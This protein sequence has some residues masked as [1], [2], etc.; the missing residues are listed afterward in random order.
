[1]LTIANCII[2]DTQSTLKKWHVLPQSETCYHNN[3]NA[4]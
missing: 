4:S 1:M 3:H 2:S